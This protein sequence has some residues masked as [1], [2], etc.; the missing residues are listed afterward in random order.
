MNVNVTLTY[1][2]YQSESV[3][4]GFLNDWIHRC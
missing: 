2:S 1:S 4:R 3:N